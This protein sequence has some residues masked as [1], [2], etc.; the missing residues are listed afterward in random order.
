MPRGP[1]EVMLAPVE[2]EKRHALDYLSRRVCALKE[3]AGRRLISEICESAGS[4]GGGGDGGRF[5]AVSVNGG[6]TRAG[7]RSGSSSVERVARAP[8]RTW[9][10][11]GFD[12]FSVIQLGIIPISPS[13]LPLRPLL[14][15]YVSSSSFQ[16]P[17]S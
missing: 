14:Y 2:F 13:H 8:E 4:G 3:G 12:P 15:K 6:A 16:F 17:T 7:G 9:L 1:V 5:T 10:G 11:S